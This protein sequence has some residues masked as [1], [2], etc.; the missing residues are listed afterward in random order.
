[1][2]SQACKY[3]MRAMLY[4]SEH[5]SAER[6]MGVKELSDELDIPQP[7]LAKVL[8]NLARQR[9]IASAKGPNG[10]FYL[11]EDQQENKL[12]DIIAQIDGEDFF[13]ACVMGLP[14]CSAQN[15]CPLHVQAYAYREGLVYQLRN[16]TIREMARKVRRENLKL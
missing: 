6:K 15:P 4:L 14:V 8:Q 3:A 10:G 1:M 2:F 12:A 13:S 7:Y 11:E 9:L 16:N 5:A